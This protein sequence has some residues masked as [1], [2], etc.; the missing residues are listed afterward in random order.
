MLARARRR[1]RGTLTAR[2]TGSPSAT[3]EP[4]S[5]A[6]GALGQT[7]REHYSSLVAL[8]QVTG[9]PES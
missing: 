5:S 3:V 2:G 4:A 7:F 8:A 1:C 6:E 9:A